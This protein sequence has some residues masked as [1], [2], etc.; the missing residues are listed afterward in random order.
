MSEIVQS[1]DLPFPFQMFFAA[2]PLRLG[3]F[4]AGVAYLSEFALP[5]HADGFGHRIFAKALA[6]IPLAPAGDR[7]CVMEDSRKLG[8]TWLRCFAQHS[9]DIS[10]RLVQFGSIKLLP[11]ALTFLGSR[12]R[13]STPMLLLGAAALCSSVHAGY[14]EDRRAHAA[15]EVLAYRRNGNSTTSRVAATASAAPTPIQGG[16]PSSSASSDGMNAGDILGIIV[17]VVTVLAFSAAVIMYVMNPPKD[18]NKKKKRKVTPESETTPTPTP[19]G[20]V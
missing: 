6:D 9:W 4:F 1:V 8:E 13:C 20:E 14:V 15:S 12:S 18:D 3:I 19:E 5:L 10:Q 11:L 16:S 2:V 7:G 17:V